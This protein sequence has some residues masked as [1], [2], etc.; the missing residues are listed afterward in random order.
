MGGITSILFSLI[1]T[2]AAN[3]SIHLM[4]D[5]TSSGSEMKLP[6]SR[7]GEFAT[8]DNNSSRCIWLLDTGA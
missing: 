6:W 5:N 4:A 2:V 3:D 8:T 7:V 1:N